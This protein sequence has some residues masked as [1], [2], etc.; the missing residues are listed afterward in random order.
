MLVLSRQKNQKINFPGLGISVEILD[1]K[2]SKVRVGVDA[3]IEVRILR[4]EVPDHGGARP[5][6]TPEPRVITLPNSLRHELRNALHEV[7]LMLHVYHRRVERDGALGAEPIGADN[8]FEAILERLGSLS[9][10]DLLNKQGAAES[11]APSCAEPSPV[12]AA[13][14]EA[15]SALVVD[16]DENERELLAGFLRM[17][18]YRVDTAADGAA[19]LEYLEHHQAPQVVLLDMHMPRCDGGSF[20]RAVRQEPELDPL[21]VFV[22]SGRGPD[23]VGLTPDDGYTHWFDKPLDPRRVVEELARIERRPRSAGAFVA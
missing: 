11:A 6:R 16:D 7:S 21:H 9:S 14:G 18:D 2:G 5:A 1:I 13:K 22:V 3:P 4:D 15:A 19:A 10:H 20:L 8:L 23:E 17:C 12:V